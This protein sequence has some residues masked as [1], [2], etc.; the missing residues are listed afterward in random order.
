M[1]ERRT[2][3]MTG[4]VDGTMENKKGKKNKMIRRKKWKRYIEFDKYGTNSYSN[5]EGGQPEMK[6]RTRTTT[7]LVYGKRWA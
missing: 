7:E 1:G 3:D 2:D 4:E 6:Q 5:Q